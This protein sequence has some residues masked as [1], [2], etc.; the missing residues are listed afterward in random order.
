MDDAIVY[1]PYTGEG[2]LAEI[3]AL[4]DAELSEPYV[5]YTY[6]Y[7]LHNWYVS[8]VLDQTLVSLL[9]SFPQLSL[10]LNE[11]SR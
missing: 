4:I 10:V 9:P 11:C 7:F 5:I 6:R 3:M 1:Q 2:D 8:Y